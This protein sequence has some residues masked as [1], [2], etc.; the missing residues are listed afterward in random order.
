MTLT[1]ISLY[2]NHWKIEQA[3]FSKN[4]TTE[5]IL[6]PVTYG[7]FSSAKLAI[8]NFSIMKKR[9]HGWILKK[10]GPNIELGGRP[11]IISFQEL[12]SLPI[13]VLWK[14]CDKIIIYQI[15]WI[16]IKTISL[17]Y[18]EKNNSTFQTTRFNHA[19]IFFKLT[20]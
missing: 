13:S 2:L 20:D 18:L 3:T 15:K 17:D 4:L 16:I 12:N 8:S 1:F 9:S 5:E 6:S 11:D 14:R 10:S 7:I 19:M